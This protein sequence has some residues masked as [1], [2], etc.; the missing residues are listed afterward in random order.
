MFS[1]VLIKYISS[2]Q[3]HKTQNKPKKKSNKQNKLK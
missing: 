1:E 2:F 3:S